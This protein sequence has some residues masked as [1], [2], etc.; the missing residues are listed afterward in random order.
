MNKAVLAVLLDIAVKRL[1]VANGGGTGAGHD[2]RLGLAIQSVGD[3]FG[4]VLNDK[5]YLLG[6]IGGMQ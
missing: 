3:V 1:L 4:E 6:H 2:H 5:L